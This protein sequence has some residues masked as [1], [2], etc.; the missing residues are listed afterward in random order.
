MGP[1]PV[2][3]KH[4]ILAAQLKHA[5][6]DQ[7]LGLVPSGRPMRNKA[8]SVLCVTPIIRSNTAPASWFLV[9]LRGG[10]YFPAWIAPN[11]PFSH[12]AGAPM[13]AM[14]SVRRECCGGNFCK[15][16]CTRTGHSV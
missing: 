5:D 15:C 12:P 4:K 7:E 8:L 9:S 13:S 1:G 11:H 2:S 14:D 16:S 6:S 3:I 10:F